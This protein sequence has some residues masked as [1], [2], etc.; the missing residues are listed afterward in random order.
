MNK[1]IV[2]GVAAILAV[3]NIIAVLSGASDEGLQGIFALIV[4]WALL[5]YQ[6]RRGR[7]LPG[8]L[9][10]ISWLLPVIGL[11]FILKGAYAGL[12]VLF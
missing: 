6:F 8:R 4:G 11:W 5:A 10:C 9:G 7:D 12:L 3:L 2:I 1:S